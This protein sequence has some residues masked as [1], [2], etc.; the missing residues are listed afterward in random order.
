MH[1]FSIQVRNRVARH[2]ERIKDR[3]EPLKRLNMRE[4]WAR[5]LDKP[6]IAATHNADLTA[7]FDRM[8]TPML[9]RANLLVDTHT[10]NLVHLA[11]F[12]RDA[13]IYAPRSLKS[14]IS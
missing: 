3:D 5:G 2:L 6:V 12:L 11:P 10:G 14:C 1:G 13:R 7:A 8:F 9:E 4:L